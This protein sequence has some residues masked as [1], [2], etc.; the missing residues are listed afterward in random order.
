[1]IKYFHELSE[2]EFNQIAKYNFGKTWLW[3]AE[4]YPQ[5]DWCGYP[6]AVADGPFMGCG[7]LMDFSVNEEGKERCKHCEFNKDAEK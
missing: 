6:N 7:S 3:L 5:P 4:N 2:D 1:M